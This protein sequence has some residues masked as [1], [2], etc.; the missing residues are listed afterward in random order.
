[1]TVPAAGK[2]LQ[3][4]VAGG[5]DRAGAVGVVRRHRG[6]AGADRAGHH[7]A[8]SCGLAD[9]L[10]ATRLRA[11][12]RWSAR[13]CRWPTASNRAGCSCAAR[14]WRPRRPWRRRRW[15]RP[16]AAAL[17]LR[18]VAGAAMAG[19]YPVGMKLAASWAKGDLG[20]LIGLVVG[21]LT[22]GSAL[23]HLLPALRRFAGLARRLCRGRGAWR[24]WAGC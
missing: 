2:R 16:G 5:G 7:H 23:P 24:W 12:A 9:R 22:L 17:V 10:R 14:C 21:A 4:G 13:C 3:Y 11:W 15:R 19:V 20:L 8:G 18:V 1:M 6:G